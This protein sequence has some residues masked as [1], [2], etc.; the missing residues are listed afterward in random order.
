MT[1]SH[2]VFGTDYIKA[3][4]EKTFSFGPGRAAGITPG[5]K[6]SL[7]K[8]FDANEDCLALLG[9]AANEEILLVAD[10]HFGSLASAVCIREFAGLLRTG[11]ERAQRRMLRVHFQLDDLI[12]ESK[13]KPE[14]RTQVDCSTTLVS[15]MLQ[16]ST[17]V[18]ANS[19]DSR[20]WL[21]RQGEIR[22]LVGNEDAPALF[23][24]DAKA[25]LFQLVP[26]LERLGLIDAATE[27]AVQI[28]V[29]LLVHELS[30]LVR[31]GMG[32][33]AVAQITAELQSLTHRALPMPLAE[34]LE[35]WHPIH[36]QVQERL[37][38][39]GACHLREGDILLLASDGID[40]AESGVAPETIAEI[41]SDS[42][43]ALE[44][45][46]GKLLERCMGRAGGN[47]NLAFILAAF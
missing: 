47:D 25:H 2:L 22:D 21:C 14:C 28:E 15:A 5:K 31:A 44:K 20:L 18:F 16:G 8:K 3:G 39:V 43:H 32:R 10:S 40:E 33:D 35:S 37:P 12:R 34:L 17:L 26:F 13:A 29:L 42:R 24:G 6:Q 30:A 1:L 23:L 45:R 38:Q 36:I 27:R 41:L 46:A 7:R 4:M 9:T 19:G 11:H